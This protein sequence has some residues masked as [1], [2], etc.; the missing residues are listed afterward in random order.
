MPLPEC[1]LNEWA[2]LINREKIQHE[3]VPIG[4]TDPFGT[5]IGIDTAT[6]W[7]RDLI[8]KGYQFKNIDIYQYCRHGW[9]K[10][11]GH[12]TICNSDYY[13]KAED[14]AAEFLEDILGETL[15]S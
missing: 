3:V 8:L 1:R 6:S 12:E 15:D 7:F 4:T 5:I 11:S 2:C 13:T 14:E 10:Y 9:G